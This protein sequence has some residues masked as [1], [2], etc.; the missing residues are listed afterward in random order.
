MSRIKDSSL[1]VLPEC[2][3][4]SLADAVTSGCVPVTGFRVILIHVGTFD[5]TPR[6][7]NLP[8]SR[9]KSI[10]TI[11]ADY[12]RLLHTVRSL[13]AGCTII[14]SAILPRPFDHP[15]SW[16][17]V[18][19]V[20]EVL[21]DVCESISDK[22]VLYNPTF[23]WFSKHGNPVTGYFSEDMFQLEGSGCSRLTQAWQM[24]LSD[25]NV[26]RG[27]HWR[28]RRVTTKRKVAP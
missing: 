3:V 4:S 25:H 20:N 27:N 11:Q 22:R 21:C 18:Q 17:R 5:I 9:L 1:L 7:Q 26:S 12:S 24:A 8:G 2:T 14:F 28:R 13:N 10:S 16:F 15:T 23:K 19:R 6:H